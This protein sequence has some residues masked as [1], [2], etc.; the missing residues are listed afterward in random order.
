MTRAQNKILKERMKKN[1]NRNASDCYQACVESNFK[2]APHCIEIAAEYGFKRTLPFRVSVPYP[3]DDKNSV[4]FDS[5]GNDETKGICIVTEDYSQLK[6]WYFAFDRNTVF[7]EM[8]EIMIQV[9]N[10][11]EWKQM[12]K[13]LYDILRM[14]SDPDRKIEV[15]KPYYVSEVGGS[16]LRDIC[17]VFWPYLR[18]PT[19]D[20]VGHTVMNVF[21]CT[22]SNIDGC[23]KKL[24]KVYK[25]PSISNLI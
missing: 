1:E 6:D 12:P 15:G 23:L 16:Q 9:N 22:R 8:L 7:H 25:T 13:V 19:V 10:F 14:F 17:L 24:A 5:F 3:D 2:A 11:E 18:L 4:S 21:I 20:N